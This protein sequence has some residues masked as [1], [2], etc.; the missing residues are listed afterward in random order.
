MI[1]ALLLS[2][3]SRAPGPASMSLAMGPVHVIERRVEREAVDLVLVIRAGSAHDPVGQE[4]LAWLTAQTLVAAAKAQEQPGQ[5]PSLGRDLRWQVD[6]ELVRF[7]L[8]CA[9]EESVQCAESLGK[10]VTSPAWSEPAFQLARAR[11]LID[12]NE[13]LGLGGDGAEREDLA[14]ALM[15]RWLYQGHPY[16]HAPQGRVGSVEV[17]ALSDVQ[18]FHADRYVRGATTL[19]IAGSPTAEAVVDVQSALGGLPG[20]MHRDATPRALQT[21]QAGDLLV[22]QAPGSGQLAVV[23]STLDRDTTITELLA[24]QAGL[25]SLGLQDE[26]T[27]MAA[28]VGPPLDL[29]VSFDSADRRV[30]PSFR[31]LVRLDPGQETAGI[32]QLLGILDELSQGGVDA[33][34]LESWKAQQRNELDGR[35]TDPLTAVRFEAAAHLLGL[36]T[37]DQERQALESL[38]VEQ[39]SQ[40]LQSQLDPDN[41]RILLLA[42]EALDLSVVQADEGEATA[43]DPLALRAIHRVRATEILP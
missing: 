31:I 13:A 32:S 34:R 18:R 4:G 6:P 1:L 36:P 21:S 17:L 23:G 35:E 41:L 42:T 2:C 39:V 29:Q 16:G 30:Q 37:I 15:D 33:S 9:V 12:L 24:L 5:S 3:W 27:G 25:Y 28:P 19:G 43:S 40:S 11:A 26:S 38:S 10:L 14:L 8:R 7:E 22:V 20:R